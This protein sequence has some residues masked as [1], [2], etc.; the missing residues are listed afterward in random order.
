MRTDIDAKISLMLEIPG[1][2]WE[3]RDPVCG[4]TFVTQRPEISAAFTDIVCQSPDLVAWFTGGGGQFMLWLN[5]MA[6]CWPVLTVVMAHHVYH[7]IE[8]GEPADQDQVRYA[9]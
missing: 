4:G 7:S 5:V 3:A 1:R 8:V 6:A 2:V 9:A